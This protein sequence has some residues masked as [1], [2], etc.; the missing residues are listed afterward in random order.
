MMA[1]TRS[2]VRRGRLQRLTLAMSA[3]LAW[4]VS[5]GGGEQAAPAPAA[6]ATSA[7]TSAA[8]APMS[9]TFAQAGACVSLSGYLSLKGSQ[10]GA[11]W[12]LTDDGGQVWK[13]A[14]PT[15]EQLVTLAQAQ[16]QRIR[17]EALRLEKYLGFEQVRP[18][19]IVAEPPR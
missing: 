12:A 17:V 8:Y 10:P 14:S 7:P 4:G 13:I 6:S 11:W 19:R 3:L 9:A 5:F 16:N 2:D 1:S 15:Q 18:C